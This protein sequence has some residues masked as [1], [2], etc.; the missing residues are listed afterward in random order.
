MKL[1][2][3]LFIFA[4][5]YEI[6]SASRLCGPTLAQILEAVCVKGYNGKLVS[7]KSSNKALVPRDMA[8]LNMFNEIDDEEPFR[9]DSLL[10]DMLFSEHFNTVAKTRRQRHFNGVYDECCRKECTLDELAGYCL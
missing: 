8:V 2:G 4:V 1:F 10:N 7:K 6:N 9:S 5:L 3:V